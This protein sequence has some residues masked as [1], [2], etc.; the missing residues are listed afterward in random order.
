MQD[1]SQG[2]YVR[3]FLLL[4]S[5]HHN[6][7]GGLADLVASHDELVTLLEFARRW[8]EA[9]PKYSRPWWHVL[10]RKTG[11]VVTGGNRARKPVTDTDRWCPACGKTEAGLVVLG[12][13]DGD[14]CVCGGALVPIWPGS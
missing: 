7:L 13:D 12:L 1:D 6:E 3:R 4:G 2:V 8:Q 11:E 9:H 10:D 14:E 5:T